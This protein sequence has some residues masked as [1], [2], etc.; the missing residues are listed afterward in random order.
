M[1]LAPSDA[2]PETIPGDPSHL[3]YEDAERELQLLASRGSGQPYLLAIKLRDETR[4]LH[5]RA[6]LG[7]P[8]KE[9]AWA[10]LQLAPPE[11]QA[12]AAKTSNRP[13]HAWSLLQ[14]GGMLP[15]SKLDD[16]LLQLAE[17]NDPTSVIDSIDLEA[18]Q[19][20]SK[21]LQN[22]AYGIFFDPSKNH[23]AWVQPK[24]LPTNVAATANALLR[25]LETR[26]PV[27]PEGDATAESAD[28]SPDEVELYRQ[29]IAQKSYEVRD[30]TATVKTRGSAQKAFSDAVKKNYGFKCAITGISTKDFLIGSHIVP[31][32]E[33]QSIRLDPTNGICLSLFVD[34]AFEKGYLLIDDDYTIRINKSRIGADAELEAQLEPYDG[35]QLVLPAKEP[36]RV[37]YLRRRRE[38]FK[39]QPN[40]VSSSPTHMTHWDE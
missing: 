13:A 22:P 28:N 23:D 4:T 31:W 24:P 6:Y 35:R 18:G 15:D 11:I 39:P 9:F 2:T 1:A 14:S 33:D 38:L 21:Y 16:V 10:D 27:M 30:S 5:L 3:I 20:L 17:A 26:F 25:A 32:S 29:K 37:E 19:A 36:P 8:D 34:R 12:V 7:G 40:L